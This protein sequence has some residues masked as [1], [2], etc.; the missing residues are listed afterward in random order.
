MIR[1][2]IVAVLAMGL[3]LGPV[4]AENFIPGYEPTPEIEAAQKRFADNKFGIFIHWGIYSMVGHG[5][6]FLNRP[7]ITTAEY[8]KLASG[9]YPIRFDAKKWVAAVK[10]SGAKYICFTTRHHDSFS[11]YHTRQS[12]YNVVDATPFGRDVLA[13]LAKECSEQGIALHLYYSHLDW[14]R[15]DYPLGRT[16]LTTGRPLGQENYDSYF[17]FM[18]E[19]IRE[20]LTNYGPIGAIWFDGKWDH[21]IDD[22]F[23]WRLDE[24]YSMIHELQPQ[25]LIANNHHE[26]PALGENIQ[27]FERDLPGENNAGYSGS[28]GISRDLP[29]ESCE[30]MNGM[31]GYKISDQSYK[32]VREL[33]HLLVRAAGR[34]ANLLLNVGPQPNGELPDTAVARL[35][36]MGKWMSVYGHTI[37]GTRAGSVAP[38]AWGVSTAKDNKLFI[39]VLDCADNSLFVP[40]TEKVTEAVSVKSGDAVRYVR[41]RGGIVL[42]FGEVPTDIDYVVELTIKK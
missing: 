28:S 37:Y 33:I 35:V 15:A 20:L 1:K 18:N 40:V 32:T 38:H 10:A 41:T 11:M 8:E 17:G 21:D 30:T 31:W 7:G 12:D 4:E 27:I 14:R 3:A 24:Q 29:L 42:E 26:V 6:W 22:Y 36:E 9:F 13:E 39:H 23:E 34:N 19:Q 16:G 5:E 2:I 25:C